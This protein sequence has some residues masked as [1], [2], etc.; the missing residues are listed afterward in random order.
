MID[1][2]YEEEIK[3]MEYEG[4]IIIHPSDPYKKISWWVKIKTWFFIKFK[5]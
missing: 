3:R 2:S 4:G 1:P 5:L